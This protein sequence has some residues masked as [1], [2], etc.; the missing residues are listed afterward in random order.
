MPSW[1]SHESIN[2]WLPHQDLDIAP[3]LEVA[4]E[5]SETRDQLVFSQQTM[6]N[7]LC[8][9]LGNKNCFFRTINHVQVKGW[10]YNVQKIYVT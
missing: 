9:F 4:S 6:V 5:V 3:F 10:A 2:G 1:G 8:L 7:F